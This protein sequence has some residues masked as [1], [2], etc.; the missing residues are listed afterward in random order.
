MTDF[1]A[2]AGD[3]ISGTGVPIDFRIFTAGMTPV[4]DQFASV[5]RPIV[6]MVG[7]STEMDLHKDTMVASALQD[8]AAAPVG[9]LIWLNHDYSVPDS[10]FGSLVDHPS[11]I[12]KGGFSDLHLA[13][14]VELENPAAAKTYRYIQKKRR[15]G[16]S[17]G[18][19]V[20]D[21][22]I[23]KDGK[24]DTPLV[25][26]THVRPV[27]WSVVGVPAN[28]RSWVENAV[29]G[30]FEN[31]LKGH[32][33]LEDAEQLAPIVKG[34]FP[35]DYAKI[36]GGLEDTALRKSFESVRA[37]P[38]PQQRILWE[39]ETQKFFIASGAERRLWRELPRETT[40][41]E[42]ERTNAFEHMGIK[43][44]IITAETI[45]AATQSFALA[46]DGEGE[47]TQQKSIKTDDI[48]NTEN[49][50][51]LVRQDLEDK[52]ANGDD[53]K[54]GERDA[55]KKAQEA[56]SH[57]YHIG[58]KDGGNVTKPGEWASVPDS[59]W[60][61]PVN[62][63]Y[64]MP[65]KAHADNAASRW[66]DA[67]NRSRYSSEEQA[68]I[69]RRIAAR[70]RSFGESS[71]E[72]EKAL[73]QIITDEVQDDG[74]HVIT[75]D[76][77]SQV[78]QRSTV[79][80]DGTVEVV[81]VTLKAADTAAETTNDLDTKAA[82]K[83]AKG[84]DDK[85][86]G[87]DDGD[88]DEGDEGDG[89]DD[90]DGDEGDGK[91]KKKPKDGKDE[92]DSDGEEGDDKRFVG[93][94]MDE[95]K[96][97]AKGKK[98]AG[99]AEETDPQRVA[100]L[101]SYNSLGAVL[102]FEA[103][104]FGDGA[105]TKAMES[106]DSDQLKS[107]AMVIDDAADQL[108]RALGVD[109]VNDDVFE[110]GANA[111]DLAQKAGAEVSNRNLKK[112]QMCHDMMADFSKGMHCAAYIKKVSDAPAQMADEEEKDEKGKKDAGDLE[113][114]AGVSGIATLEPSIFVTVGTQLEA[115]AK[116]LENL[117]ALKTLQSESQGELET[118]RNETVLA[119]KSLDELRA[120]AQELQANLQVYGNTPMGR[121]TLK[122]GRTAPESKAVGVGEDA[123]TTTATDTGSG[124]EATTLEDALKLTS[125][126]YVPGVGRV[127]RWPATVAKGFR[128][129]LETDQMACMTT[130]QIMAYYDGEE[131]IVPLVN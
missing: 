15:L 71:A 54:D 70:Q 109:D 61:D 35:T 86:D 87:A 125:V 88:G 89:A 56:R 67:S 98:S 30:M 18:C 122:T 76:D 107:L 84:D 38:T 4:D 39:P 60:G 97:P 66:G 29:R 93:K 49:G 25:H 22:E 10:L 2:D 118:L 101:A 37:R 126:E 111:L 104:A 96:K 124:A 14:E 31:A 46:R 43:E 36:V 47:M 106:S 99:A 78:L 68:I 79:L 5:E 6:R 130:K 75:Y 115:V 100:L 17:V 117:G 9:L 63:A 8:M 83:P 69:G 11:I 58:V 28:Q 112:L 21:Y 19:S 102:G 55:A 116:G 74:A 26:I 120:E 45:A 1:Y 127:R 27:E 41:L 50:D 12:H 91:K 40:S 23:I 82:K 121:P 95:E 108:L 94:P 57:K 72:K 32:R 123:A 131:A 129:S 62:Y 80:E 24:D 119:R 81:E 48:T 33:R 77:G 92:E 16:C 73:K 51:A 52:A 103:R 128:P 64:P 114:V 20:E 113:F 105:L 59:E 13:V 90:G 42:A 53:K 85:G 3:P 44:T 65:D 7:S 34:L 110:K